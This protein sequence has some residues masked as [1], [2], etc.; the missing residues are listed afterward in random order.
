MLVEQGLR[1]LLLVALIQ[2]FQFLSIYMAT[3]TALVVKIL[4]SWTINHRR[5]VPLKVPLWPTIF[6]PHL[7]GLINYLFWSG[8]AVAL[9]PQSV[10]SVLLLFFAAGAG[11]IG[12]CFFLMG[13]LGGLDDAARR[14][15]QQAG[16]MVVLIGPLCRGLAT[17]AELGARLS[18]LSRR[19]QAASDWA[20]AQQEA[21]ELKRAGKAR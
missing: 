17:A 20:A 3:L 4:L 11:S 13:L 21:E 18:P 19:T 15:L 2:R 8:V 5:I 7:A 12:L 6:A 16:R 1:L 14:E 10:V 9:A